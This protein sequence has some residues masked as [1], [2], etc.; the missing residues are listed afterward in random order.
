M[1]NKVAPH[2]FEQLGTYSLLRKYF[3]YAKVSDELLDLGVS[4]LI[5]EWMLPNINRNVVTSEEYGKVVFL[6][7][8]NQRYAVLQGHFQIAH[9]HP[10]G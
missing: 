8:A 6:R 10:K 7:R 4:V 2:E 1:N 3:C 5:C 9:Q